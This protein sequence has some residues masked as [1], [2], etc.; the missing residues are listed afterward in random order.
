MKQPLSDITQF[1]DGDC[2]LSGANTQALRKHYGN[3]TVQLS[4]FHC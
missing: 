3:T 1:F 4:L 2:P